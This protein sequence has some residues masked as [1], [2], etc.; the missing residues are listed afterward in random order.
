ML[1]AIIFYEFSKVH[2]G[3]SGAMSPFE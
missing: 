2:K 1:V 3:L